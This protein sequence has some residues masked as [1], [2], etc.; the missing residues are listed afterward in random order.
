MI[1]KIAGFRPF[2]AK[3]HGGGARLAENSLEKSTG[4]LQVF[5]EV[6][7]TRSKLSL[8]PPFTHV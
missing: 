2:Q 4:K 3:A 1:A 7:A 5:L 8:H 6:S